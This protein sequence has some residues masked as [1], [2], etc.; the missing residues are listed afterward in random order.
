M[1]FHGRKEGRQSTQPTP[2]T[3]P[4]AKPWGPVLCVARAGGLSV[5]PLEARSRLLWGQWQAVHNPRAWHGVDLPRG[6]CPGAAVESACP[7]WGEGRMLAIFQGARG[8]A[9]RPAR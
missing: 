1:S 6:Q 4:V 3:L 8:P 2:P 5:P 7:V 9:G